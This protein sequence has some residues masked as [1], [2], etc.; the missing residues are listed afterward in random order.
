MYRKVTTHVKELMLNRHIEI[1]VQIFLYFFIP[2]GIELKKIQ[3]PSTRAFTGTTIRSPWETIIWDRG[4]AE[5][6][7]LSGWG[8]G[9]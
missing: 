2:L 4:T 5:K 6:L 1:E 8:T 7:Y 3:N 9:S